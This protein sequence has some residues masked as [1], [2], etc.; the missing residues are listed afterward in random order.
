M[1]I[2]ANISIPNLLA[3]YDVIA[4][5]APSAV[6]APVVKA[7]SYGLGAANIVR[8]LEGVKSP[9]LYYVATLEEALEIRPLTQAD[10]V[11]FGGMQQGQ[12][13][14]FLTHK[15]TPALKSLEDVK[16]WQSHA[17]A[18]EKLLPC[19][20][21]LDTAMN[22]TGIQ[23]DEDGAATACLEGLDIRYI[24]THFASSEE[25]ENPLNTLQR[26][27]FISRAAQYEVAYG[28]E[29]KKSMAN[30]SGIFNFSDMHFDMVRAGGGLWGIE[31]AVGQAPDLKPVFSIDAKILQVSAI[32]AGETIGYN[33]LFTAKSS[34]IIATLAMGYADGLHWPASNKAKFYWRG[35]PCIVAGSVS[36]DLT[37]VILPDGL[38]GA[39][40]PCAG[41]F[42]ELIGAHQ[43]IETLAQDCGA[44][45]YEMQIAL[46]GGR[47]TQRHMQS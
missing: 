9:Y 46:G 1:T 24:I 25:N 5:A 4:R 23:M 7:D 22:R 26:K 6:L 43:R 39:E 2:N 44:R 10:I 36:M 41:D 3:N 21:H 31:M 47:R 34:C 45:A 42:M 18:V 40:M 20:I 19:H 28:R 32:K 14:A 38:D 17:T 30:S 12:Q 11:V 35:K 8:A 29:I 37:T 16:L 13:D 27:R 15:L 33:E